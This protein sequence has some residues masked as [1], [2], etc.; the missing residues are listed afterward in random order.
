MLGELSWAGE[1]S[2]VRVGF[3]GCGVPNK[4]MRGCSKISSLEVCFG[5]KAEVLPLRPNYELTSYYS[6][7]QLNKITNTIKNSRTENIIIPIH[8]TSKIEC[9]DLFA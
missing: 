5:A 4:K 3:V 1:V 2:T 8:N 9:S 7:L 6:F